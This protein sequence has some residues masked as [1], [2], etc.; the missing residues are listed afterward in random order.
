MSLAAELLDQGWSD[1]IEQLF[2]VHGAEGADVRGELA[3]PFDEGA[4]GYVE[5]GGAARANE[6]RGKFAHLFGTGFMLFELLF[7]RSCILRFRR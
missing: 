3:V 4:L 1:P 2:E 7:Q 6:Y 5:V